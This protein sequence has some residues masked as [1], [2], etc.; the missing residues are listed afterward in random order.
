MLPLDLLKQLRAY[1]VRTRKGTFDLRQ[2]QTTQL[3]GLTPGED[4]ETPIAT[5]AAEGSIR[6]QGATAEGRQVTIA[7]FAV[8][9][10]SEEYRQIAMDPERVFPSDRAV[11]AAVAAE[12]MDVV[13]VK[14]ELGALID[15]AKPETPGIVKI[16]FPEDVEPLIVPRSVV[17]TLLID[18]CVAKIGQ[19]LRE[20][21]NGAYIEAK[22]VGF[23]KGQEVLLHSAI[24]DV[25][26]RT[27]KAAATIGTPSDFNFRFW[28][29]LC[30]FLLA[31]IRAKKEK[32]E[33][34]QGL[35]QAAYIIGYAVFHTKGSAQ[36]DQERASDYRSLEGRLRKPPFLFGYQELYQLTD[37]KGTAYASKH[38]REFIH[39]FL[40]DKAVR[41]EQ[42]T[43]PFLLRLHLSAQNKD[44]FIQ[45][46]LLVPVF[47]KKL[48]EASEALRRQ[49]LDEW[50]AALRQDHPP[51]VSR[52]DGAFRRDVEKRIKA[53]FP[54]LAALANGPVLYIAAEEGHLPE[55]SVAELRR[56]FAVENILKPADQLLELSR[57]ELLK[58][59]R[60]YL[61]VWQTMPILGAL[62]RF[63]RRLG[64]GRDGEAASAAQGREAPQLV[65]HPVGAGAPRGGGAAGAEGVG[66]SGSAAVGVGAVGGHAGARPQQ[67][68]ATRRAALIQHQSQV[69]SLM[70]QRVPENKTVDEVLREL[71]EKWN[72]LY[73]AR[74]KQ[75]LVEDVNALVRDFLRPIRRSLLSRPP[76]P[77]RIRALATQL[78][79]SQSLA[80][81][82]KRDI[83]QQYVELYMLRCLQVKT[84]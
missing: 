26:A 61:P 59:V 32:T 33:R 24:Q 47:L 53:G 52:S 49:Y 51:D 83:L 27:E 18:A 38:G 15:A 34:D 39:G 69:R 63:F 79:E 31:D 4:I 68:S 65:D 29:Q 62:V 48:G 42:E 57:Q 58:Q 60:T 11:S 56:C 74:R 17:S 40:R 20:R 67:V 5:L 10:L 12:A 82:K 71:A 45:R 46:D 13:D 3:K 44:Y 36:R 81:I 22:L 37:E 50:T 25:S 14:V 23:L 35:C 41:K 2:F 66:G 9:A 80:G 54:L 84:L 16:Q 75:N 7:G 70:A 55:E 30:N 1:A 72:P 78:C 6:I 73:E 77:K 19:H 43:I 8:L 76:D 28:T 64:S 21:E